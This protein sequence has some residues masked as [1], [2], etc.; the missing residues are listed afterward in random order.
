MIGRSHYGDRIDPLVFQDRESV[1]GIIERR[2]SAFINIDSFRCNSAVLYEIFLHQTR[3]GTNDIEG[4][5]YKT[6]EKIRH[7]VEDETGLTVSVGVSFSKKFAKLGSDMKKPNAVTVI[8]RRNYREKVWPLPVSELL[9]VGPATTRRLAL[10]NCQT[11]GDLA[12]ADP[13]LI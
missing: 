12:N 1:Y 8:T 5:G 9:Y 2:H 6:A 10:I 4:I 11:I 13:D 7:A 3:F